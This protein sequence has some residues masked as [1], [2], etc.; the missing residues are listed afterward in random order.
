MARS[1]PKPYNIYKGRE[2][3]KKQKHAI[4]RLVRK[5]KKG[6]AAARQIGVEQST[7]RTWKSTD[8]TFKTKLGMAEEKFLDWLFD[9]A[10][11]DLPKNPDK[12]FK[13]LQI[14]DRKTWVE[15]QQVEANINGEAGI[16]EEDLK[17]LTELTRLLGGGGPVN[18]A[19]RTGN[20]RNGGDG[21]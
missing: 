6:F 13:M 2:H 12:A 8:K 16:R 7:F 11:A 14:R 15:V 10:S 3:V 18:G 9:L 17:A 5:G 19:S 4:V 1:K 20:S 21:R